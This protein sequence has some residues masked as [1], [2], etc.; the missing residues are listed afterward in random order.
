MPTGTPRDAESVTVCPE[1]ETFIPGG[2]WLTDVKVTVAVLPF[3][4]VT[5]I[6]TETTVPSGTRVTEGIAPSVKPDC[7]GGAVTF[8]VTVVLRVNPPPLAVIV[9]CPD[10]ADTLA[11]TRNDTV[12]DPLTVAP[13]GK[14]AVTPEGEALISSVT[15]WL[16]PLSGVTFRVYT[17]VPPGTTVRVEGVGA[18]L[19]S[20]GG[21]LPT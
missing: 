6:G 15:G 19:K 9:I 1:I 5:W 16:N 7:A 4:G 14:V 8:N 13:A 11:S 3:S 12:P 21:V 10:T 2:K 18:I 20:G 17:S